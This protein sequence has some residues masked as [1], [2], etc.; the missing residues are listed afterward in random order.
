MKLSNIILLTTALGFTVGVTELHAEES[1][2]VKDRVRAY[3]KARKKDA[4]AAKTPTT[5]M[6]LKIAKIE[7]QLKEG[8]SKQIRSR[9]SVGEKVRA[10][11]SKKQ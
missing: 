1:T 8:K 7:D 4:K 2:S 6:E 9:H 5:K 10:I 3:E 11:E